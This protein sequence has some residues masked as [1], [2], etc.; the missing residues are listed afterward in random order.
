MINCII[1]DDE[2]HAI[3]LLSGYITKQP[4]LSLQYATTN[5]VDAFN[6]IG[7]HKPDLIFLDI[8]MP[9][10]NGIQ[11][12]RLLNGK[13]K[14]ILTTAYAEYALEGYEHDIADYLLKPIRFER[15]LKAVQKVTNELTVS[16]QTNPL[17]DTA[18]NSEFEFIMIK[19]EGRNKF[20]RVLLKDIEWIEAMG[21]YISIHT[22]SGKLLTLLTIKEMEEKLAGQA[23]VRVHHS[24]IIAVN[25]IVEL[26]G[27][28]VMIGKTKLPVGE[29][30]KK[31]F[32]AAIEKNMVK[33]KK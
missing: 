2:Q 24:Y 6:H 5:P 8:H 28:Q 30:Y 22:A 31:G 16:Q 3:D 14:V 13:A 20:H 17:C 7:K 15:F 9:E 12:L 19:T 33:S 21:N 4:S 29:V 1:V 25:K 11:F 10:L 18:G 27:H 23:F 32:M 26:E